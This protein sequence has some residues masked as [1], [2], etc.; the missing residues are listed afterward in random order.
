MDEEDTELLRATLTR[1]DAVLAR[2][3][4]RREAAWQVHP[5]S[6]LAGDDAKT[7]PYQV[8]HSVQHAVQ[9]AVDHVRCLRS[10]LVEKV[11]DDTASMVVHPHGQATL[12][13]GALEN[14]AR[15]LWLLAPHQRLERVRRRLALQADDHK[16]NRAMAEVVVATMTVPG[17]PPVDPDTLF[18]RSEA[19]QWD[20]LVALFQAA[21]ATQTTPKELKAALRFAGYGD[22][23]RA[24]GEVIGKPVTSEVDFDPGKA[25]E[26]AWRGC[27]ALAHGDLSNSLNQLPREVLSETSGILLLRV[28]GSVSNLNYW[29]TLTCLALGKALDLFD[30]RAHTPY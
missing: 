23:A 2:F 7:H 18:P 8:S 24:A 13:R 28:T 10:C 1:I 22:V 17:Q 29:T 25:F 12:L 15:A 3:E 26:Y 6:S 21:G 16:N 30:T 19:E 11:E 9:V 4:P 5:K 27:S 14:S 20:Q